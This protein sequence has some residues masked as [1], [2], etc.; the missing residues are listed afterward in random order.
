MWGKI[1]AS[2]FA[3]LHCLVDCFESH[4]HVGLLY[5]LSK[6]S[7]DAQLLANKMASWLFLAG[8]A[9]CTMTPFFMWLNYMGWLCADALE[10]LIGLDMT[11]HKAPKASMV[12]YPSHLSTI[13]DDE[14]EECQEEALEEYEQ[15]KW[16]WGINTTP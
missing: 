13:E 6:G 10:D 16:A 5:S 9:M 4:P 12:N 15:C 14:E 7:F 3:S 11:Y 8:W 2:L 1:A